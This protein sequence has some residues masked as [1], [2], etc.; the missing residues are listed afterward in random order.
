LKITSV[1]TR[2]LPVAPDEVHTFEACVLPKMIPVYPI[3]IR[4]HDALAEE[5]EAAIARRSGILPERSNNGGPR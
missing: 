4:Q 3:L 1:H 2:E 5:L